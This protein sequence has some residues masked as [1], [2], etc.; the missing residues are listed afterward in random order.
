MVGESAVQETLRTTQSGPGLGSQI[1][2]YTRSLGQNDI[3]AAADSIPLSSPDG[4]H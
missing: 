2:A 1:L 4:I 3:Q